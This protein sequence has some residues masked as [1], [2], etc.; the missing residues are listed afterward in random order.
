MLIVRVEH[1]AT[2]HPGSGN[3]PGD[4]WCERPGGPA[5][6]RRG[7][8]SREA[9]RVQEPEGNR[10]TAATKYGSPRKLPCGGRSARRTRFPWG[11][12]GVLGQEADKCSRG[13]RRGMGPSTCT[14]VAEIMSGRAI[15][16][17]GLATTCKDRAHNG[18]TG[19]AGRVM[20][21]RMSPYERRRG[22]NAPPGGLEAAPARVTPAPG[23]GALGTRW[24]RRSG[25]HQTQSWI[26][27]GPASWRSGEANSTALGRRVR[28]HCRFARW[29]K[30]RPEKWRAEPRPE[31]DSGKPTVRDRRGASGNVASWS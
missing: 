13:A 23:K 8:S 20:V 1:V 22:G 19:G 4:A 28:Q 11:E 29:G 9:E 26:T 14:R 31:P 12:A 2:P 3:R 7:R 6:K 21:W 10:M 30:A 16:Q 25:T 24:P 17:Q 18:S 27:R 5:R 15:A